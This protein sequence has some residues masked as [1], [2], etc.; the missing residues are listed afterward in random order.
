MLRIEACMFGAYPLVPNRLVYPEI[1]P[2]ECCYSTE[3]QLIKRLKYLCL[4][5]K[6]FRLSMLDNT[7]IGS[8]NLNK[9]KWATLKNDF[10]YLLS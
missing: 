5:P 10:N 8:L 4:R 7:A 1:Y 6:Q 3:N 2:K 9:F